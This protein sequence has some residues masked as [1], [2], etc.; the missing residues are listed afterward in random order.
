MITED[1]L[2]YFIDNFIDQERNSSFSFGEKQ[3]KK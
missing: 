3:W 1:E 2:E